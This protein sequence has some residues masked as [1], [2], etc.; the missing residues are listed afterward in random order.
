M[1]AGADTGPSTDA[2]MPSGFSSPAVGDA[3]TGP[4]L[5]VGGVP[6]LA[7]TDNDAGL[8]QGISESP[9]GMTPGSTPGGM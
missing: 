4:D 9:R 5:G 1:Q 8:A 3:T 6:G 2:S 7:G